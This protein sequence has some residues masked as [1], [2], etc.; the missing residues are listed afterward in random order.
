[1]QEVPEKSIV[2]FL[3]CTWHAGRRQKHLGSESTRMLLIDVMLA[4]EPC[5]YFIRANIVSKMNQ[6]YGQIVCLITHYWKQKDVAHPVG[7]SRSIPIQVGSWCGCQ[8]FDA[9]S[10]PLQ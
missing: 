10:L 2:R 5:L 6:A 9:H 4:S 3:S 1:M 7:W 8:M